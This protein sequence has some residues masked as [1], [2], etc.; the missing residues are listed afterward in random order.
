MIKAG[1]RKGG[2][3]RGKRGRAGEGGGVPGWHCIAVKL[4]RQHE[5]SGSPTRLVQLGI[6]EGTL[7]LECD[8]VA[9][10][11]CNMECRGG[12]Q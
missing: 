1:K 4:L 8:G 12:V 10:N 6:Q 7:T 11:V 9:R 2:Q 3:L 5:V